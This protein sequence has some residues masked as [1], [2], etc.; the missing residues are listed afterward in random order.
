MQRF[1]L[2]LVICAGLRAETALVLPFFNHSSSA[3]LDW[4][5]ESIAESVHDALATEGVLTLDRD[6]RLEGYRRLSLRPG[7][8]L[9]LASVIKVGEALDAGKVIYGEYE[10]TNAPGAASK[11]DLRVIARVVDLRHPHLDDPLTE[12]APLEDLAKLQARLGWQILKTLRPN[13]AIGEAEFVAARPAVRLDAVES[14]IRGLMAASPEQQHRFFTQAARLDELYSQPC[15]RL[16]KLYWEKKDY[17]VAA[18]WLQRVDRSDPHYYESRYFLGLCRYST[19]DF[20]EAEKALQEVANSVPL[21]EVFNNLGAAQSRLGE[22]PAAIESFRKA[23]EGDSADPDYHFN[24]GYALWR[25]GQYEAAVA[26]FRASL[27]RQPND[28]EATTFLGIA[29]KGQGQRP[30]DLRTEGRQR[31]KSEYEEAA[32]R[33]L[34]AELEK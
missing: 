5:G 16:G 31:L 29:L 22:F 28:T 7:A 9:T 19:G 2:L 27:D 14:Y 20:K 26:S 15:F 30:G 33:Q 17:R 11:G 23:I 4:V 34:R 21:N 13:T 6:D 24:L 8:E 25:S 18:G 12:S 10:V 3:N 32:Y 1:L